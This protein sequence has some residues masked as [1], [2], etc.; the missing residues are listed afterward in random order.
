MCKLLK[1]SVSSYYYWQKKPESKREQK[2]KDLLDHNV[3]FMKQVKADMEVLVLRLNYKQ[4][5]SVYRA[6]GSPE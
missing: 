2:Q 4:R 3:R 1:V 6:H 5:V